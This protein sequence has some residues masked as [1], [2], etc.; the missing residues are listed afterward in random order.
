MNLFQSVTSRGLVADGVM[1]TAL[2]QALAQLGRLNE[3][4]A[5]L[6]T[7]CNNPDKH[8]RPNVFTYN[9]IMSVCIQHG[10]AD[11]VTTAFEALLANPECEP[12]HV[13]YGLL[14]RMMG[15]SGRLDDMAAALE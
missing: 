10:L 12:N 8:S 9:T 13:T 1:Y 3:V 2:I 15:R 11:G 7:M 6:K 14:L 4:F 5:L